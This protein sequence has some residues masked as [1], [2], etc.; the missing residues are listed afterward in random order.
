MSNLNYGRNGFNKDVII[1]ALPLS[2]LFFLMGGMLGFIFVWMVALF[3][4]GKSE[5]Y[6]SMNVYYVKNQLDYNNYGG[7]KHKFKT[8]Y[9]GKLTK[10]EIVAS[11]K[12]MTVLELNELVKAIE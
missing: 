10:E 7:I 9:I 2:I 8:S 1:L 6:T 12:E 3:L 5:Y 11:L 4:I